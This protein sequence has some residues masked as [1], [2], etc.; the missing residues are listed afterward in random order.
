MRIDSHVYNGYRIPPHYDSMIGKL[1]VHGD[2]REEAIAR[3]RR[4]LSEFMIE[5]ICT[6][7]PFDQFLLDTRE[8]IEGRYDTGFIE[9]VIK[10]GH[11]VK[12]DKT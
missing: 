6:T 7:I 2:T 12:P 8:F 5:G 1:I 10:G 3:C 9:R 4:A 11:F